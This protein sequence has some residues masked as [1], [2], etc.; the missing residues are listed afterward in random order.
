MLFGGEA[1]AIK[2]G[3]VGS[4]SLTIDATD[5]QA[6]AGSDLT[7]NYE[8]ASG[9]VTLDVFQTAVAWRVDVKRV[10][11]FWHA[12]LVLWVKRTGDGSSPNS[13]GTEYMEVTTVDQAFFTGADDSRTIPLQFKLSGVSISV[14][15][16]SYSTTIYYTAVETG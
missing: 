10:D 9:A 16:D 4:W 6:G 5:L 15:P 7:N 1:W 11:T 2:M 14:P 13:G 8:S 12:D 3:I